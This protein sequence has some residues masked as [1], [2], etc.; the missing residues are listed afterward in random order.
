MSALNAIRDHLLFIAAV[1]QTA[2]EAL[3]GAA[4]DFPPPEL[5]RFSQQLGAVEERLEDVIDRLAVGVD[6]QAA[7]P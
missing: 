4:L 6:L 1:A 2:A 3:D 7:R 5:E